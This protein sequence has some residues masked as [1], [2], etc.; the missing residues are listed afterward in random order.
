M[1]NEFLPAFGMSGE[2]LKR[3]HSFSLRALVSGFTQARSL[4]WL[5]KI[6]VREDE[7]DN[8]YQKRLQAVLAQIKGD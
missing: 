4:K 8:F 5:N 7:S 2:P 1:S 6:V 3:E